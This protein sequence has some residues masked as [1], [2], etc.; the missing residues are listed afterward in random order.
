MNTKQ[1]LCETNSID[2]DFCIYD[3]D[4]DFE[5]NNGKGAWVV[6]LQRKN[7]DLQTIQDI[8]QINMNGYEFDDDY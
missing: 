6:V 4:I 8:G 5:L 2:A 1:K 7:H 3:I